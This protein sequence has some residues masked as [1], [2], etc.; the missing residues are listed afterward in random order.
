MLSFFSSYTYSNPK[1]S[2]RTPKK[3][4]DKSCDH[5][6]LVSIVSPS[7]KN[8]NLIEALK[9]KGLSKK[10]KQSL[11]LVWFVHNIIWVRDINNKINIGLIKL[12]EDLEAFNSYPWGYE[13]FKM[14]IK[15]LLTPLAPKTVNLYDFPWA[16]M[17]WVFEA[18]SYLRQQV[19][20]Q[21]EVSCPRILRWLS[22]KTYKN[23]KFPDLFNPSKDAIMHPSL[24]STNRELKMLLFLTLRSVQTLSNSM[25]IDIIKMKFFGATT[26]TRKII[27]EGGLVVVDGLSGDGAVGGGSGP[28]VRANNAPL[29]IF[30]TN[31]YEVKHDVVINAIN[32]LTTSVKELTS[33][34]GVIPSKRILYPSTPLEIKAKR[35]RKKLDGCDYFD[36]YKERHPSQINRVIWG[37]LNKVKASE[38]KQNRARR[39]YI[40]VVIATGLAPNVQLIPHKP[41]P[42]AGLPKYC[43]TERL[44]ARLFLCQTVNIQCVLKRASRTRNQYYFLEGSCPCFDLQNPM[45]S[46]SILSLANDSSVY[47]PSTRWGTAPSVVASGKKMDLIDDR[48]VI[49]INFDLSL[50]E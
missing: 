35:R 46:V 25:I 15:Y 22:A 27:L 36:W 4:K 37:L 11:C 6:D 47:S 50:L 16:F 48:Q 34:R 3:G 33:K 8:K 5:D 17:A 44:L 10:H 31:H 29:T 1:K 26:M 30:K 12:S 9:G 41:R 39:C 40:V 19:N 24:V 45:I 23:V 14:T 20:Y 32:V 38:E 28:A 7:F 13:S 43:R 49:V 2:P 42:L 21:E 18:I